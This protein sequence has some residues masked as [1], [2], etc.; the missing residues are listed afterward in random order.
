MI[1]TL[2][3]I[4]NSVKGLIGEDSSDET[5]EVIEDITDT[6]T[7]YQTR[8]AD[9]TNWEEKYKENDQMW[10]EKYKARFFDGSVEDP[11]PEPGPEEEEKPVRFEDLFG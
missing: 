8:T 9:S 1:K 2:E 6:I 11:E 7:D 5:L 10:R 3:E 4:L